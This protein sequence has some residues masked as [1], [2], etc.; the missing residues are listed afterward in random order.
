MSTPANS[1]NETTTGITGFTGTAFTGSPATQYNVQ[2]GGASTDLLSNVAPS[3]TSGV[4]LVSQG[5][6][7]NP[8]FTT[9]VVAGGGTGNTTFTAYSLITAGTTA[10]GSFQNV[11]GVGTS[12]QVLTSNGASSLPTWQ[13]AGGSG[14]AWVRISQ[15]IA[16]NDATVEFTDLDSTY[17]LYQVV[18]TGVQSVN[19]STNFLMRTSTNN[20]VSFD[21][22]ATNYAYATDGNGSMSNSSAIQINAGALGNNT[23]EKSDM[24]VYIFNPSATTFTNV[25]IHG[26]LMNSVTTAQGIDSRGQRRSAADVDAIQFLY[27]NGNIST[28]TF[29]LYGLSAS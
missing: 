26:V 1:I 13:D 16:S 3:A 25:V 8:S 7:A 14:G 29:T 22:G 15:T 28:G 19:D 23:N 10:T 27:N 11:S 6:S 17:S 5:S 12:G 20:G 4:P 2:V 18:I 21:S 9:A 24:M